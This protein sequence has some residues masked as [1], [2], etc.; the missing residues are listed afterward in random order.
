MF[1]G[2]SHL[3]FFMM[4]YDCGCINVTNII[5]GTSDHNRAVSWL[6]YLDSPFVSWGLMET[7]R[8]NTLGLNS[9]AS[10][11][12]ILVLEAYINNF[13]VFF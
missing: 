11:D 9:Q 3:A 6:Q 1:V 13:P 12:E 7:R 10:S 5:S 2:E 4:F 8:K